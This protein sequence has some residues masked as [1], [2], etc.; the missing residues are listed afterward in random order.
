[1]NVAEPTLQRVES[2]MDALRHALAGA[3]ERFGQGLGLTRTQ[4]EILVCLNDNAQTTRNL[5]RRLFLTP[6]AVTQTIDTLV[7]RG[8]ITRRPDDRD[9]RVTHLLL[10]TEGQK[11]TQHIHS[12]RRRHLRELIERL[13]M[14]E[15]AVLIT[16]TEKLAE[17]YNEEPK[18]INEHERG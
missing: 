1:M 5:A 6:S 4:L 9:H 16:I 18:L 12:L 15:V 17:L 3:R 11:L 2:A 13:S 7:R 8:L 14:A 10:S